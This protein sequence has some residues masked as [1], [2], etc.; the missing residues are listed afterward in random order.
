M[1]KQEYYT[2]DH[3]GVY[4]VCKAESYKYIESEE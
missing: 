4:K 1:A 3:I 2:W